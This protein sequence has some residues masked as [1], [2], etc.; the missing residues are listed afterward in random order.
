MNKKS[1]SNFL[2]NAFKAAL[3]T[4]VLFAASGELSAQFTAGN[5]VTLAVGNGVSTLTNT[6]NSAFLQ[7]FSTAGAPTFSVSI[8]FTGPNALLVSGSATSEGVLTLSPNGK[9]LVM[10]GYRQSFPGATSLSGA[11]ST[12]INRA[13]GVVDMMGNFMIGTTTSTFHSG[14]NIRGAASNGLDDYWAAGGSSGTT[15]LGNV[16]TPTIVQSTQN[17][18]RMVDIVGGNLLYSTGSGTTGIY[19]V[20]S[21]LPTTGPVT[22][23][24]IINTFTTGTGSGSPYGFFFN[25]ANTVCYVADSRAPSAG[26]GIQ[27][28]VNAGATW[29]LAYTIPTNSIT[30][31]TAILANFTLFPQP[32][33][34]ATTFS[35]SQND[36][37]AIIDIG[38]SSTPTVLSTA[39]ANI[40]FR[41]LAPSPTCFI[42]STLALQTGPTCAG[43]PIVLSPPVIAAMPSPTF[44][45][46]GSTGTLTTPNSASTAVNGATSG[47]SFSLTMGNNCGTVTG[48]ISITAINPNPVVTTSGSGTTC[49]GQ[50]ARLT[51]SG[52]A[53]TY[54]WNTGANTTSIIVSPLAGTNYTVNVTNSFSCS[55]TST[56]SQVVSP[57][58]GIIEATN[59]TVKLSIYPNPISNV[60][61]VKVENSSA[62]TA[63]IFDI[64]GNLVSNVTLSQNETKINTENLKS[65][66]YFIQ[67]DNKQS[68]KFIKN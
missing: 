29:T 67:L 60:L 59:G 7:E 1:T 33:L 3:G 64:L 12:L 58:T 19:Q 42:P 53:G 68:M 20:G 6:G 8:P 5:F 27:K 13:A 9:Y 39:P 38:A 14:N 15:Y 62:S 23:S 46:S 25:S 45:W 11:S 2:K 57:C 52:G 10:A 24:L 66:I 55:T 36:L 22:P 43:K 31:A 17:N 30:G 47:S 4:S 34:V 37:V 26:G 40:A 48:S 49:A 18:T 61:V 16:A 44:T 21:G 56:I 51:A 32:I 28:W 54:S 50:S 35:A 63:K 65:G 41:G